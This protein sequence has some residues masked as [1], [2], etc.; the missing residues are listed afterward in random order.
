MSLRWRIAAALAGVAVVVGVL[1][2]VGAYVTT[3]QQLRSSI[4]ESLVTRAAALEGPAPVHGNRGGPGPPGDNGDG[5]PEESMLRPASAAQLVTADGSV[6]TCL[7]GAPT[8]PVDA[9]DM[10]AARSN[11]GNRLRTVAVGDEQ[12][13]IL[14]TSW[15][16]GR[17]IQLGRDLGENDDVLATLRLRLGIIVAAGASLAAVFGWLIARRIA[18]PISRLRDTAEAIATTQ[19]LTT[20]IPDAGNDEVG[21][22]ARSFTAMVSALGRSRLQQQRLVSDASHEMRTPMTSLTSNL[23]LLDHFDALA[24]E[25]RSQVL[26]A[27][28]VDVRE[29]T[30][31]LNELVELATDP[32]SEDEPAEVLR[33]ADVAR[34]IT[35]R[36]QRRTGRPVSFSAEHADRMVLARP[37]MLERAISNLLDNAVKYSPAGSPLTVEVSGG[38]I[39]VRDRG[40]GIAPEDQPHVF[41]R[42]Y[43]AAA[44]RTEPGSGLGLAIVHQIVERHGGRVLLRNEVGGGAVVGFE[45]P[46]VG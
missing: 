9:A 13:R 11:G 5:C 15:R 21:S 12:Y 1:A 40:P 30:N 41:D 23:E 46:V 16:G 35:R 25:E 2:A 36:A 14:T 44:V 10:A 6:T 17:A 31:L 43:R 19:D 33:L 18:R 7:Q 42:F 3:S 34:D 32:S 22:L 24:V 38:R 37:H 45:L 27:V 4:D 29:L 39:E 26:A 20:P 8:L 28:T